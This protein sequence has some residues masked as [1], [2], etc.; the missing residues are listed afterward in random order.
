MITRSLFNIEIGIRFFWLLESENKCYP[1]HQSLR[2]YIQKF[3]DSLC[4]SSDIHELGNEYNTY[5]ED[6]Q[7]IFDNVDV[8]KNILRES[9]ALHTIVPPADPPVKRYTISPLLNHTPLSKPSPSIDRASN[10]NDNG[11]ETPN[12]FHETWRD[13][14]QS[15]PT[16]SK[17]PKPRV[18]PPLF[19]ATSDDGRIENRKVSS[20][21]M[22]AFA[23]QSF[24]FASLRRASH[25]VFMNLNESH[26]QRD[27]RLRKCLQDDFSQTEAMFQMRCPL[28]PQN[29]I[30]NSISY[31]HVSIY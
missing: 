12:D 25:N 11:E 17:A 21:L 22:Q 4:R 5:V 8:F 13:C 6:S 26:E 3:V 19:P 29:I 10:D 15:P 27:E 30:L 23:F 31:E 20:E 18:H 1:D 16:I 9:E 24:L 7:S 2:Q 28:R 14:F